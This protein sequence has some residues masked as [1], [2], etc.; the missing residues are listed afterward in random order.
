MNSTLSRASIFNKD[1]GRSTA[2]SIKYLERVEGSANVDH[3]SELKGTLRVKDFYRGKNIFIT[4]C[5]G[6]LAKVILEKLF[7]TCPDI[8]KLYIMVRAKK[9]TTPMGRI[10]SEILTSPCFSKLTESMG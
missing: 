5:T 7:R 4:G 1:V 3:D 9:N 10:E 2:H 8:G 6:F